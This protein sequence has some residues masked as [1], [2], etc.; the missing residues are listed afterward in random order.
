MQPTGAGRLPQS[1]LDQYVGREEEQ[2]DGA[3]GREAEERAAAE[4]AE[5]EAKEARERKEKEQRARAVAVA[6]EAEQRRKDKERR[7]R[8]EREREERER[9]EKKREEEE[10]ED[11]ARREKRAKAAAKA[12]SSKS[13]SEGRKSN[14]R[15]ARYRFPS[16]V[17]FSHPFVGAPPD[18]SQTREWR[19]RTGQFR[20]EAAFLGFQEWSAPPTQSEWCGHRS[21]VREDVCRRHPLR[22]E[23]HGP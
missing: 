21:T 9:R 22:R 19:D 7:D 23:D 5:Q 13:S 15:R 17:S 10:A 4:R 3:A 16:L 1:H 11:E 6:S 18:P 14:E 8:E 2:D 12:R 20:V